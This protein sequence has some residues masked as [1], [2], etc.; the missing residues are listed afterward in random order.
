MKLWMKI[1]IG[2]GLGVVAGIVLGEKASYVKPIGT[3]F[4]NAIKMLIIPLIF[5]SIIVGMTSLKDG[6]QLGRIGLKTL[7]IYM[8]TTAFAVCIGL[9][10][11]AILTPGEGMVIDMG[12][13]TAAK[14]APPFIDTIINIVPKNPLGALSSG[15]VLQVIC[16]A[17]FLGIAIN[18]TG[19][20][21]DPFKRVCEAVAE[22]MYT[23]TAIVMEFAPYGVF[24]LMAWVVGHYGASTLLPLLKII[25]AMY[26]AAV[27]H[28]VVVYGSGVALIAKLNP[29]KF[30]KGIM[31]A[32]AVAFTTT[33]SSGSL[34]VTIRCAQENL[35][36]SKS[37]SSFVLPLGAT[38]N[39]DGTAIYQGV[40]ALFVAQAAGIE[41]TTTHYMILIL[42]STLASIG[43]A[44]VPGAGLIMLSVTL[45]SI[46]L[47]MEG[48]ALVAGID[49][50][51][52]MARTC[53]NVTGDGMTALL[54]AKSEGEFDKEIYEATEAV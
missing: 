27:L 54:V 10:V 47:P 25:L 34:P 21:A 38:V 37:V 44:G 26:I 42:S 20:K 30:F 14:K 28:A 48:I 53:V 22:I 24:A 9:L 43:T 50:V 8:L 16:F 4:I 29:I 13:A 32:Q 11:S 1:M 52:D 3:L 41:L 31:D 5:S 7:A 18:L 49:R 17:I 35:G 15:K 19:E 46:G 6:K 12:T 51:L 33:S 45:S 2:L 39:M 23:L 36:V 40:V